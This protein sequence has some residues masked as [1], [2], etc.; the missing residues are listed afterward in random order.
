M[1]GD[2]V[3]KTQSKYPF[4]LEHYDSL[5]TSKKELINNL[6]Y[7]FTFYCSKG[8]KNMFRDIQEKYF[9]EMMC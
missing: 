3:N 8:S 9:V 2:K 6:L 7:L 4:D 5:N 1:K